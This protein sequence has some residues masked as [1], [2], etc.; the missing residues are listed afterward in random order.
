MVLQGQSCEAYQVSTAASTLAGTAGQRVSWCTTH[1]VVGLQ[2][3]IHVTAPAF[4]LRLTYG[5]GEGKLVY[6]CGRGKG[7]LFTNSSCSE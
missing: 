1:T 5:A 4:S 7:F 3:G 2:N 6:H